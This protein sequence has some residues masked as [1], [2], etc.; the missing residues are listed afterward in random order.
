MALA[1][2]SWITF[3]SAFLSSSLY[4]TI[5]SGSVILKVVSIALWSNL[6]STLY[7]PHLIRVA[8]SLSDTRIRSI[9]NSY[10]F[11][12]YILTRLGGRLYREKS[13]MKLIIGL[14]SPCLYINISS[15]P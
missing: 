1:I 13:L 14:A 3:Y 6:Y 12:A 8:A 10:L 5:C 15:P 11:L 9:V 7:T 4:M 2:L